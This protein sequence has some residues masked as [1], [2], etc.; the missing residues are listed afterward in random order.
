MAKTARLG[1]AA[2]G[3]CIY[4]GPISGTIT[5]AS[6]D[7]FVNGI[8]VAREGDTVTAACGHTGKI[9]SF[10]PDSTANGKGIARLGDEFSGD[11]NGVIVEG[12]D[13]TLTN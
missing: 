6:E 5:E 13:D 4:H 9:S 2:D 3:V 10:S 7:V 8:G 12:S 11:F 1:D